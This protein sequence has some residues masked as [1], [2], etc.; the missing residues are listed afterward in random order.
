MRRAFGPLMLAV[1]ATLLCAAA[2]AERA[3]IVTRTSRPVRLLR[4]WRRRSSEGPGVCPARRAGVRL[5]QGR[6]A[7]EL[8]HAGRQAL[9][10]ARDH[11]EQAGRPRRRRS[12]RRRPWCGAIRISRGSS[13]AC[14]SSSR[15]IPA[16]GGPR[17][18]LRTGQPLPPRLFSLSDRAGLIRL[19]RG[20]RQ[21]RDPL[22]VYVPRGRNDEEDSRRL[23]WRRP[24]G[25]GR[26]ALGAAG[27]LSAAST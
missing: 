24:S 17:K 14:A 15:R 13:A 22:P 5:R 21:A 26:A 10:L 16:G 6:R 18:A 3:D 12:P 8:L 19:G 4:T 23:F 27:L 9:R 1:G 25:S 7:R 2:L 11:T 20:P